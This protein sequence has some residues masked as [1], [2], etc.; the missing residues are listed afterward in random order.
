M[1]AAR[2]SVPK[3]GTL[4]NSRYRVASSIGEGGMGVVL[5]RS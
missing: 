2:T 3:P 1:E 4:V 5:A